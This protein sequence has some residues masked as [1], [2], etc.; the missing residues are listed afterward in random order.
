MAQQA[1]ALGSAA[2]ARPRTSAGD[3]LEALKDATRSLRVSLRSNFDQFVTGSVL[4]PDGT[5]I[6]HM[7]QDTLFKEGSEGYKALLPIVRQHFGEGT[8]LEVTT[9]PVG[10]VRS[11]TAVQV[12]DSDP[13]PS[14]LVS[15]P[16]PVESSLVE[17][18]I[19]PPLASPP[20]PQ[21]QPPSPQASPQLSPPPPASH[22]DPVSLASELLLGKVV[23][24]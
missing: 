1:D 6:V 10:P 9:A 17:P 20:Q 7:R 4:K 23:E 21:P 11:Q 13:A 3:A 18:P 16:P 24:G 8:R 22:D 2:P 15:P 19:A 12:P 14:Q 5:L